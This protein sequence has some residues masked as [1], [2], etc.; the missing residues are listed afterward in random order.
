MN[1]KVAKDVGPFAVAGSK[2]K[3]DRTSERM[4]RT[5]IRFNTNWKEVSKDKITEALD[6][7]DSDKFVQDAITMKLNHILG[8]GVHFKRKF[9]KMTSEA[10]RWHSTTYTDLLRNVYRYCLSCGFAARSSIP[11]ESY[12]GEPVLLDLKRVDTFIQSDIWGRITFKFFPSLEDSPFSTGEANLEIENVTIIPYSLPDSNGRI[13]SI[14]DV[15]KADYVTERELQ[16]YMLMACKL[17]CFPPLVTECVSNK[18]DTG[19]AYSAYGISKQLDG[20]V[21]PVTQQ[22]SAP[23]SYVAQTEHARSAL[24]SLNGNLSENQFSSNGA[25]ELIYANQ[26]FLDND[27]SLARAESAQEPNRYIEYSQKRRDDVFAFFSIPPGVVQASGS[28]NQRSSSAGS[29]ANS[30]VVFINDQKQLKNKFLCIVQDMYD[31]ITNS[32]HVLE[33]IMDGAQKKQKKSNDVV[34]A[35]SSTEVE[36]PGIPEDQ[37][38][39][40]L[41]ML[42]A[43]SYETLCTTMASKHGLSE[44]SFNAKPTID[45]KLLNGIK[46]D[47]PKDK[48]AS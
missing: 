43:L 38:I 29:S 4:T 25:H 42:G 28:A 21:G 11:H 13:K 34:R 22:I 31:D 1:S 36:M 27:R 15:L 5:Q 19:T 2:R 8:A 44:T 6:F 33:S 23:Q 16:S 30:M 40:M 3:H 32:V 17:K 18:Q 48:T 12:I 35:E 37:V 26:V 20:A 9:V 47:L 7:F 10:K 39:M 14:A 24:R 41:Y 45:V 46:P